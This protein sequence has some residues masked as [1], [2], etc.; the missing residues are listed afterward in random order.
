MLNGR[1]CFKWNL[2]DVNK[3]VAPLPVSVAFLE[4]F[5]GTLL[6]SKAEVVNFIILLDCCIDYFLLR[7]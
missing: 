4:F 1:S 5:S 3:N 2:C 7:F 6:K